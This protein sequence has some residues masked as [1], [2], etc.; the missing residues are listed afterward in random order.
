V[1]SDKFRPYFEFRL[2]GRSSLDGVDVY[3]VTYQQTRQTPLVSVNTKESPETA[4]HGFDY[5][6]DSDAGDDV[7]GRLRGTVWIDAKT[8]Q[9]RREHR[10]LTVQP[11]GVSSPEPAVVND[12]EFQ[13]SDFGMLTPRKIT[14]LQARVK[15][16][17]P[18]VKEIFVTM[19]YSNFSKPDVEV[20]SSEIKSP[21][22]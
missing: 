17:Q 8:F 7:N 21:K 2:A 15:K 18:P 16:G 11:E 19:E 6:V 9:V 13:P 1:L 4:G 20:K 14:H 5:D 10:E 22:Q 3:E 12:F